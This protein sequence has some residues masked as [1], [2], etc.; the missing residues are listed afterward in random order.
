MKKSINLLKKESQIKQLVASIISENLTNSNIY[1]ATVVDCLLSND[2]SHAKFFVAFDHK[3]NDGI[4]AIRNASG[5]I[6]KILSKT[7]KWRKVPELHFYI[8]EVEKKAF[9]IDQILNSFSK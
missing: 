7:L 4:E 9:E 6:R 2:L 8:D 5:F 3:E 1:N